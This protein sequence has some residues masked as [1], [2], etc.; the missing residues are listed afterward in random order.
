MHVLANA[1]MY[2]PEDEDIY[3]M[4]LEL[5]QYTDSEMQ[6]FLILHPQD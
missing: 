4:A 5:K 1:V 3:Q 2:N 6:S